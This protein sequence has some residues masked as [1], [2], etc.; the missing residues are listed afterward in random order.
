MWLQLTQPELQLHH[1]ELRWWRAVKTEAEVVDIKKDAF[2]VVWMR[3]SKG[4]IV[5]THTWPGNDS[6]PSG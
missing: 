6:L 2:Q 5:V 4:G 3:H 1:R